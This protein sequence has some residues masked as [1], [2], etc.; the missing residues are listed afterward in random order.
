MKSTASQA[1]AAIRE[2]LKKQFP[3]IKFRVTSQ[4]Y[5]GGS[6]IRVEY[7][8]GPRKEIVEGTLRK[9]EYGAFNSM[10]DLYEYSNVKEDVPQVKFLMV[11]RQMSESTRKKLTEKITGTY[12]GCQGLNYGDY[13]PKLGTYVCTLVRREFDRMEMYFLDFERELCGWTV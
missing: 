5:S 9:Y 6:S 12:E 2:D 11:E 13:A 7:E 1:A 10:I 3:E 8:D 4:S